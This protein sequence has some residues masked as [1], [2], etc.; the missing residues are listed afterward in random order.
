MRSYHVNPGAGLAGLTLQE[1]DEPSP[2]PQEVLVRM[3]AVSLNFRDLMILRGIYPLP[4]K[5][6]VVAV[7]DGAG[8]VAAVGEGVTRANVGDR[9]MAAMFPRWMDGPFAWDYAQQIGG[10][11]DG[12]LTEFAVLSE[13]ALVSM[14]RLFIDPGP[15]GTDRLPRGTLIGEPQDRT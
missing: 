1:H 5:P 10:S 14:L 6:D 2:G 15:R 12:M 13:E 4:V 7:S 9:V 8:E 11:L 3:R